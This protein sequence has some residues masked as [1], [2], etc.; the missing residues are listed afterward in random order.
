MSGTVYIFGFQFTALTVPT[1][2]DPSAAARRLSLMVGR[3]HRPDP[4]TIITSELGGASTA[5]L[6]ANEDAEILDTHSINNSMRLDAIA[7]VSGAA[8]YYLL[9]SHSQDGSALVVSPYIFRSSFLTSDN[10]G[11]VLPA[12]I[13]RHGDQDDF[14]AT[15]NCFDGTA[16]LIRALDLPKYSATVDQVLTSENIDGRRK[17]RLLEMKAQMLQVGGRLK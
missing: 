15:L 1:V 4:D 3:Q 9:D 8:R 14:I 16:R 17:A 2:D 12:F 10:T 13:E 7:R 11:D 6:V 5:F